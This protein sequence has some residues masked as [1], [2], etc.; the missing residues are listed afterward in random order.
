MG[1]YQHIIFDYI[2]AN[3]GNGYDKYSGHFTAPYHG[4]YTFAVSFTKM[5]DRNLS[6]QVVKNGALIA[7]GLTLTK[8]VYDTATVTA[9]VEL[10][11]GDRVWVENGY[12]VDGVEDI[13]GIWTFFSGHLVMSMPN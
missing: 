1:Q 10:N 2:L 5:R 3:I 13:H 9:T 6:V 8:D 11:K 4:L 7:Q 12:P